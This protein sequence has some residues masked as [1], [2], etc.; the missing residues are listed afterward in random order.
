ML[1]VPLEEMVLQI[2]L[3]RLGKA[4]GFLASV[5]EP[6][7]EKSVDAAIS[8]LQTVGALTIQDETLTPLG[9]IPA[10]MLQL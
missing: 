7:P 9:E 6:P 10:S 3:L 8:T 5:L 4:A 1:R 2:H